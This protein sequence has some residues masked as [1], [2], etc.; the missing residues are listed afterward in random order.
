MR[1]Y[2][3][4]GDIYGGKEIILDFS[5]N[6]NPLG[7]PGEV[8]SFLLEHLDEF[9]R[10]PDS[11]CRKLR[12]AIS[13]S[14]GVLAEHILCGNG[15]ADLIYRLCF[16]LKPDAALVF[17]PTFSEYERA[18]LLSGGKINYHMLSEEK[19]FEVPLRVLYDVSDKADIVFLCNPNNPTGRLADANLIED[20][21]ELCEKRGSILF[22]D[23]CFLDFTD[24]VSSK[25]LMEKFYNIV[26]LKA[27]TKTYSMAGLRLGYMMTR[28]RF[29]IDAAREYAQPW[30]VS[31]PAQS[32]GIAA[33][34]SKSSLKDAI[35]L[36]KAERQFLT[37]SLTGLGIKVYPS[38]AN[39]L[40]MKSEKPLKGLLIE[41]GILVRSCAN[42]KGLDEKFTRVCVR[43]REENE[44]L[45]SAI[46]EVLHG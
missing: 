24:A 3:H 7:M 32:A 28:N 18:V 13:E 27:F 25:W 10:Y 33:L 6:L 44:K 21:A 46:Q 41:K 11:E 12:A 40:L 38:D 14:E 4:G 5:V 45:I 29:A 2:E 15:A 39:F 23:E 34:K 36:I 8:K 16:G 17:A 37:S 9:S 42:F 22:I 19:G 20:M 35:A 1:H 26:I 30:S 31:A 43:P